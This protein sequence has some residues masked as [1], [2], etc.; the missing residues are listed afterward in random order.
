[1]KKKVIILIGLVL[2][3][4]VGGV[5]SWRIRASEARVQEKLDQAV[6]YLSNNNYEQA[7]LEFNDVIKIDAQE[8]RAYQGLA[9]VFILQNKY[10]EAKA[11]YKRG[12]AA[13]AGEDQYTLRLGLAGMYIDKGDFMEARR[14]F[15]S[16]LEENKECIAAYRG[17]AMVY[18]QQGEWQK[19]GTI[20]TEGIKENAAD[21]RAYNNLARFLLTHG[22]QDQA[23]A[24]I[25]KSLGLEINQQDAYSMLDTLFAGKWQTLIDKTGSLAA[26]RTTAML[27]FYACRSEENYSQALSI[28]KRRLDTEKDNLKA[29][30]LAATCMAKNG[31][32]A[33]GARLV[34][35]LA[36]EDLNGWIMADL[37]GYYLMS[38]NKDQA[39]KWANQCLARN[40]DSLEAIKILA[41]VYNRDKPELLMTAA[42]RMLLYTWQPVQVIDR[43]M[44]DQGIP[45][46]LQT[47]KPGRENMGVKKP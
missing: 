14:N 47:W 3:L 31:D 9:R 42:T 44:L 4:T 17:L 35:A 20:L 12:L 15:Q 37:S 38:G 16:I 21:F 2:V 26:S 25:I 27:N 29:R 34:D 40:P 13:I 5:W 32:H 39:V 45:S 33:G 41:D 19:A 7:V 11:T 23:L 10:D 36:R 22:D 30:V 28:Y 43:Q 24:N 18:E 6:K 8:I 46:F 1:M